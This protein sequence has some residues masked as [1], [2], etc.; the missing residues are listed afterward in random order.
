[1]RQFQN[2]SV[3]LLSNKQ[4]YCKF[5]KILLKFVKLKKF[6]FKT[7]SFFNFTLFCRKI[8][9]SQFS[10]TNDEVSARISGAGWIGLVAQDVDEV[11]H[12]FGVHRAG[13]IRTTARQRTIAVVSAFSV[14]AR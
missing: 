8:R 11:V 10:P 13:G 7:F 4:K 6:R 12:A 14:Y 3:L 5:F 1:M 9:V 2:S